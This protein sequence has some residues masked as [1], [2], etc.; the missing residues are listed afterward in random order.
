VRLSTGKSAKV[1]FF[2]QTLKILAIIFWI[3]PVFG[4]GRAENDPE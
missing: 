2:L 1:G 3:R 4:A